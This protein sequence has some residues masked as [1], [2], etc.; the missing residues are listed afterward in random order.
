MR[1]VTLHRPRPLWAIF[2]KQIKDTTKNKAV[3]IQFLLFPLI[4][5][6]LTETMTGSG[7]IPENYFTTLFATMYVG[8]TPLIVMSTIIAEEKE[9]FTL[10]A[11]IMAN[12][13]PRQYLFGIGTYCLL[14]CTLGSVAFALMS[15]YIGGEFARFMAISILAI[16]ASGL[17]G[18][19]VGMVSRN[20][21]AAT[22]IGLPLAMVS[23]FLPM[24]VMF[25]ENFEV[26]A[27]YL[28]TQQVNYLINDLSLGNFTADRFAIIGANIL[29]LA[30]IFMFTYRRANLSN[31]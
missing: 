21:M 11:L 16:I 4:A 10:K 6:I 17:L 15:G 24:I 1:T 9:R 22:A 2:K 29:L 13:K 20:Q 14:M 27:K 30:V 18:A 12:V 31:D 8:F 7:E 25:N 28:Y 23:S 5:F 3:L 26:F 19:V